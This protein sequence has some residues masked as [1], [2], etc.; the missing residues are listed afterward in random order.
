MKIAIFHNFM[1]NIGGAEIVVLHMAR[2]LHADVYTTNIDIDKINKMGFNDISKNIKSIGKVPKMAPFRHQIALWRFKRLNLKNKYDKYIIAGDW[3]VSAAVHNKPNIWYI[4]SPLNE[5]WQF[6]DFIKKEMLS[7]WK[8][9]I[10]EIWVKINRYLTKK[11]ADHVQYFI[12]NSNNVKQRVKK[13][14][15]KDCEII[16]P[17]VDTKSYES[18]PSKGYWLSVN[19]LLTHKRVDLQ[20]KAFAKMP[21]KKLIIVGSYEK[22]VDQFEKY[23]KYIESIKTNNI[24]I[25]NWVDDNKLK[26]LYSECEGFITTSKDEDFGMTAIEAMASG[27]FCIA[28]KE[29]GYIESIVDN[30]TGTLIDNI[31]D[32]KIIDTIKSLKNLESHKE[33]CITRAK[34]FDV[35]NF[36]NQIQSVLIR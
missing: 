8:K 32:Q 6:K 5:L 23:V 4:H 31:D 7:W 12:C 15:K 33:A 19:R 20:I 30:K 26:E 35:E 25:L 18:R 34:D 10:F 27:K 36:I 9:P 21:D 3:A 11:Y 17:P 14:Y 22:N 16:Y 13:Y 1:D 28:P 2:G 29:G 24:Q